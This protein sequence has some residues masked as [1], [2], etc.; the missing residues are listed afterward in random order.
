LQDELGLE[1]KLIPSGGGAFEVEADG[2]LVFSKHATGR[3][4][5]PGE[6]AALIRKKS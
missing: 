3:F 4:P 5:D 2:K 1:A 6:V